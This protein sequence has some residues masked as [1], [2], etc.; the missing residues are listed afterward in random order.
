M[1]SGQLTSV[2]SKVLRPD[3]SRKENFRQITKCLQTCATPRLTSL[4]LEPNPNRQIRTASFEPCGDSK[5]WLI[6]GLEPLDD[7]IFDGS[8]Y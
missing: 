8:R 6:D 7:I 1:Q 5:N 2:Q 3:P 4:R